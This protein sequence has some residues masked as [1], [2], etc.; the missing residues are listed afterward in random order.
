MASF[1]VALGLTVMSR[2]V[3]MSVTVWGVRPEASM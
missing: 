1:T 2:R 3:M